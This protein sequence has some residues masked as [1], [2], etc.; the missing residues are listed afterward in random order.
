MAGQFFGWCLLKRTETCVVQ[1]GTNLAC[2]W[3]AVQL[4]TWVDHLTLHAACEC[5]HT[6]QHQA[7]SHK[8]LS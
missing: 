7:P 3:W 5:K 6:Y 8:L 1:R 2:C 4:S